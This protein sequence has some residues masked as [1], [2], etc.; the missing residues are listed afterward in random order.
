MLYS[1]SIA[2]KGTPLPS[3]KGN[4]SCK[5]HNFR[6]KVRNVRANGLLQQ[7]TFS[8]NKSSVLCIIFYN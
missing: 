3:L 5:T 2:W 4:N 8:L 6:I 1:L 7:C